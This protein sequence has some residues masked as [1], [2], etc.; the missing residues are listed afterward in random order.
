MARET[1]LRGS[2]QGPHAVIQAWGGDKQSATT[3]D[4]QRWLDDSS[5]GLAPSSFSWL[6]FGAGPRGCLGTRSRVP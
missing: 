1:V 2:A 3:F 6:P 5:N 4:P